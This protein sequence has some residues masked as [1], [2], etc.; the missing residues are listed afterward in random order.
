MFHHNSRGSMLATYHFP[1][2]LSRFLVSQALHGASTAAGEVCGIDPP[3]AASVSLPSRTKYP[4][5]GDFPT[6]NHGKCPIKPNKHG[7]LNCY[8]KG[9]CRVRRPLF[10]RSMSGS[11]FVW[12]AGLRA[13]SA[14]RRE[15]SR[16]CR[17]SLTTCQVC[18]VFFRARSRATFRSC[19]ESTHAP[20]YRWRIRQS[21]CPQAL[22]GSR[23][24]R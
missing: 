5:P 11:R 22:E 1:F 3:R 13:C 17:E 14:C 6:R 7:H 19:S 18:A 21:R 9:T 8:L 4:D 12:R 16:L 23:R 24:G 2:Q 20:G 10:T 15:T